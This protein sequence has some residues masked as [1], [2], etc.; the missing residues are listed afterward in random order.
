LAEGHVHNA[1]PFAVNMAFGQTIRDG[2]NSWGD[3]PGY[4]EKWPSAIKTTRNCATSKSASEGRNS[5]P[6]RKF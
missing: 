3:A 1:L 2:P 6:K 5:N 4:G